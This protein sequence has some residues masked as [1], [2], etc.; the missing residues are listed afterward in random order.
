MTMKQAELKLISPTPSK[1]TVGDIRNGVRN[2]NK[3]YKEIIQYKNENIFTNNG[4]DIRTAI[5]NHSVFCV[6]NDKGNKNIITFKESLTLQQIKEL[7]KYDIKFN[8]AT[9]YYEVDASNLPQ[10]LIDLIKTSQEKFDNTLLA[11]QSLAIRQ[12]EVENIKN[13][14]KQTIQNSI[15]LGATIASLRNS[16]SKAISSSQAA[17]SKIYDSIIRKKKTQFFNRF[18]KVFNIDFKKE[19][20]TLKKLEVIKQEAELSPAEYANLTQKY[21][22]YLTQQI[23][24]AKQSSL[25][26]IVRDLKTRRIKNASY[27]DIV[28]YLEAKKA[29]LDARLNYLIDNNAHQLQEEF[30]SITYQKLGIDKYEWQT[31]EDDRVREEHVQKNHKIFNFS[32]VPRPGEEHGC[33]CVAIA[34]VE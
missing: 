30:K 18:A 2:E 17:I 27:D 6:F 22:T 10:D 34:I 1:R 8:S 26:G 25:K 16:N 28:K 14:D 11:I 4:Q 3:T 20:Q 32:D 12:I 24:N 29:T 13:E 7:N 5:K 9:G 21:A 15:I 19:S 23:K 31:M 33:R